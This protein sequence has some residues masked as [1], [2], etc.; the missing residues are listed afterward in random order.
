MKHRIVVET[1]PNQHC[2]TFHSTTLL[3]EAHQLDFHRPLRESSEKFLEKIGE[4]GSKL[5]Q[6]LLAIDGV[7]QV[8]I[9]PYHFCVI[10]GQAFSWED[11][12]P[13][14]LEAG[15]ALFVASG[16]SAEPVEVIG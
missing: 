3:S 15:Q 8:L 14:I 7:V 6:A 2:L 12:K 5:V 11:I 1:H 9:E 16:A 10:K 13:K 4:R